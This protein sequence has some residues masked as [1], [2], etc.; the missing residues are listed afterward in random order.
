MAKNDLEITLGPV[1]FDWSRNTLLDFYK[2]AAEM[3]VDTVHIGEVVC[4]KRAGLSIEDID[5]TAKMLTDAGKKVYLST[6]TIVANEPEL[7]HIRKLAALPYQVE[8]NDM[9]AIA[10]SKGKDIAAGPHILAYNP[11]DV[12]VLKSAGVTRVSFPVELPLEAVA[13]NIKET[14]IMGEVFAHGKVPLA[15]SWRCYS[16]RAYGHTR[17]NCEHECRQDPEGIVIRN[18][19]KEELFTINGTSILSADTY[20]M[21]DKIEELRSAGVGSLRI[22]PDPEDTARVVE[23][24]RARVDGKLSPE[25]GLAKIKE[26]VPGGLCNGWYS[27]KAGREFMIETENILIS[28]AAG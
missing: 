10:I 13:H 16:A 3:D 27:G 19:D 22:S 6:L 12:E 23:I 5:K 15:F 20:T 17:E 26:L 14:G 9:S 24:F 1:L 8:A 2:E 7:E 11:G 21:V 25:E 28:E 18:L 4:S